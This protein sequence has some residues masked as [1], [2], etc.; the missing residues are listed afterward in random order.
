VCINYGFTLYCNASLSYH[1][2]LQQVYNLFM[3]PLTYSCILL[4]HFLKL[5]LPEMIREN[6]DV[7][8]A[9]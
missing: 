5:Q 3:L 9:E 7:S 6:K 8:H 1:Y 4:S 2:V